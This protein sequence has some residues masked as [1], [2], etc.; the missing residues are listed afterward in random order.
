MANL[1]ET[2]MDKIKIPD[3]IELSQA[4]RQLLQKL[5]ADVE[6]L[7]TIDTHTEQPPDITIDFSDLKH[8]M[9]EEHRQEKY[10]LK[11]LIDEKNDAIISQ[12]HNIQASVKG[13]EILNQMT[14]LSNQLSDTEF[15]LRRQLRTV[16]IMMGFTIWICIMTLAAMAAQ[17]LG[18]F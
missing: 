10:Q 16:K 9:S 1:V 4:D 3:K 14:T 13:E 2:L 11:S 6:E 15:S 17:A 18:L 5:A 8:F 7:K 12:L